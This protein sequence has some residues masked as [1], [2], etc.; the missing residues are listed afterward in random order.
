VAEKSF[1][2][3]SIGDHCHGQ[4]E[5]A[6]RMDCGDLVPLHWGRLDR[7]PRYL[8]TGVDRSSIILATHPRHAG[9]TRGEFEGA[10]RFGARQATE[11]RFD[12]LASPRV[13]RNGAK[14]GKAF[15]A[16]VRANRFAIVKPVSEPED[17]ADAIYARDLLPIVRRRDTDCLVQAMNAFQVSLARFAASTRKT[18]TL[19]LHRQRAICTCANPSP[20]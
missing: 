10:G 7:M 9:E 15:P 3:S 16:P 19:P 18:G 12:C 11:R 1:G 2:G 20:W 17:D 5:R 14:S 13:V 8:F 6:S 4:G